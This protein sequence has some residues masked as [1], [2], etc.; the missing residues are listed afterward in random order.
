MKV[1][2]EESLVPQIYL[3]HLES[4]ASA[5]LWLHVKMCF[6]SHTFIPNPDL[7]IRLEIFFH[8]TK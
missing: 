1:E 3:G 5:F 2:F 6:H 8:L 7:L 4:H